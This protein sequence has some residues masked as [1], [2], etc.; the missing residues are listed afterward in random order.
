MSCLARGALAVFLAGFALF[1]VQAGE[2]A[3]YT[4]RYRFQ[5]GETIRWEVEHRTNVKTT[6][7]KTTQTVETLSL[8]VKKW[9]V[10][11]VQPNGTVT[12]E[13]SVESADM[14]Q[15][16]SGCNEI[17]YNSKTDATAPAVFEQVAKSIGTPLSIITMDGKGKVVRRKR[18]D[19]KSQGTAPTSDV[20]SEVSM[21]I[22]LPEEAVPVGH[23]WSVPQDIDIPLDNGNGVKRVKALQQ[24]TLESIQTGVATIRLSTDILTPI[25]DPAIE[26]QLIQREVAGAVR[27]DI[28]AGRIIGQQMDIDKHVVGFRGEASALHYVN[29]FAEKLVPAE[30]RTAKKD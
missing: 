2:P 17:R 5:P 20:T 10:T 21:T 18:C 4:L 9:R 6:V 11:D 23:T 7:S 30:A 29:R 28:D 22:P 16:L 14:R 8:S 19:P 1:S 13:H 24:F 25:T 15:R 12:F 3:K 27:F 26:S